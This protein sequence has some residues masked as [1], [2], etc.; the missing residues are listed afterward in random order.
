MR[1]ASHVAYRL[2]P[3]IRSDGDI[4]QPKVKNLLSCHSL[5]L[6]ERYTS[7]HLLVGA[8]ASILVGNNPLDPSF[9]SSINQNGLTF[10]GL[11]GQCEHSQVMARKRCMKEGRII[12]RSFLD[13]DLRRIWEGCRRLLTCDDSNGDGLVDFEKMLDSRSAD[14]AAALLMC[15]S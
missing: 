7:R 2:C 6:E 15:Q 3:W 9:G 12:V 10:S 14:V 5:W 1:T 13:R 4:L 8:I 11:E